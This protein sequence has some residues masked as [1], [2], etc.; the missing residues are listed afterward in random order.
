MYP[1]IA[2]AVVIAV[3]ILAWR[4]IGTGQGGDGGTNDR[5][6]RPGP[7]PSGPPRSTPP[8]GIAPDDD[9]A[10]LA[11]LDRMLRGEDKK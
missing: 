4:G 5:T 2:F 3:L 9:P 7:P 10:F 6:R 1:L 8:R 11:Q